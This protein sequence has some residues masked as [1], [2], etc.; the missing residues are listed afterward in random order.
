RARA[1]SST[2]G[3][4]LRSEL[5]R[6]NSASDVDG[7]SHSALQ[8]LISCRTPSAYAFRSLAV[9]VILGSLTFQARPPRLTRYFEIGREESRQLGDIAGDTPCLVQ[10][11]RRGRCRH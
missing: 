10:S 8:R 2:R 6:L 3:S 9:R 7:A 5:A 4:Q 1:A 11:E